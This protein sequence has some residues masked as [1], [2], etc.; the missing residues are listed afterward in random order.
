MNACFSVTFGMVYGNFSLPQNEKSMCGCSRY[1]AAMPP[2][3]L[4]RRS[5][6][7]L[8]ARREM[9]VF[10]THRPELTIRLKTRWRAPESPNGGP[11]GSRQGSGA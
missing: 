10:T 5:A 2:F 1:P 6:A 4:S 11:D 3:S 7:G 8:F 9:A